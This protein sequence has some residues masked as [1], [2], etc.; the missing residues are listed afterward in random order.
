MSFCLVLF[1]FLS[2]IMFLSCLIDLFLGS[3]FLVFVIVFYGVADICLVVVC[4]LFC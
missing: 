4:L 3:A 2:L 1:V